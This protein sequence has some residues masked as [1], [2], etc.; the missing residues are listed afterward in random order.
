MSD[1]A[2]TYK[3]G[4]LP[5]GY[6]TTEGTNIFMF[7]PVTS[8]LIGKKVSFPCFACNVKPNKENKYRVRMTVAGQNVKYPEN[9]DT[10]TAEG[11][12]TKVVINSRLST[13]DAKLM[14]FDIKNMYLQTLLN[15]VEYI[16]NSYDII[17]EK[18][19]CNII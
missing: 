13:Q 5:Q 14:T 18:S 12:T 3:I 10:P 16:K 2:L 1:N 4:S 8:I 17:P 15:S 9:V 7:I 19:N 6:A 11:T